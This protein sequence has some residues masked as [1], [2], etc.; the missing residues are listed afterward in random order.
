MVLGL[1]FSFSSSNVSVDAL[2]FAVTFSS[3]VKV[4]AAA[5]FRTSKKQVAVEEDILVLAETEAVGGKFVDF[6]V[7]PLNCK[8]SQAL[9]AVEAERVCHCYYFQSRKDLQL[10]EAELVCY[11]CC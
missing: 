10:A 3:L 7:L 9:E 11:Y 4:A 6:V 2:P 1:P 8:C 5:S